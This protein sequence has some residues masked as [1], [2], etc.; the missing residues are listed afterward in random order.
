MEVR[1][2]IDDN[3]ELIALVERAARGETILFTRR[4]VVVARLIATA[5]P[6]SSDEAG[7]LIDRLKPSRKI[8]AR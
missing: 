8:D 1:V 7:A 6:L 3:K 5:P 4:G 2:A